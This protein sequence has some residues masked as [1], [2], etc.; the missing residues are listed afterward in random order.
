MK[1]DNNLTVESRLIIRFESSERT[2]IPCDL[3][4]RAPVITLSITEIFP[5]FHPRVLQQIGITEFDTISR[6][7]EAPVGDQLS[8][9]ETKR[10]LLEN[11]YRYP[12]S[13]ISTR[14]DLLESL[15]RIHY[16]KILIP[17]TLVQHCIQQYKSVS[18]DRSLPEALFRPGFFLSYIQDAWVSFLEALN[19]NEIP[20]IP[21]DHPSLRAYIDTF[22][23]E[24]ILVPAEI[25]AHG[26]LPAWTRCGILID[27][28]RD[29]KHHLQ[30]L[31]ERIRNN[32]PQPEW[33]YEEWLH[34][35]WIWAEL[36]YLAGKIPVQ[37]MAGL[38]EE[39]ESSQ[40]VI[41]EQF[42]NWLVANFSLIQSLSYL[43]RPI[44]VHQIP[45][46]IQ[47]KKPEKTALIVF[48]GLALDQWLIIREKLRPF[49]KAEE[50]NVFAWV[51]TLTSI[52]RRAIFSGKPPFSLQDSLQD[53]DSEV[54]YWE[55]LWSEYGFRKNEIGYL[56]G[57]SLKKEDDILAIQQLADKKILGIVVNT[58]DDYIKNSDDARHSLNNRIEE[59]LDLG[60]VQRLMSALIDAGYDIFITSDHGN[61]NCTG[62]GLLSDG[63][64][65]DEKSLRVRIYQNKHLTDI[66]KTKAPDSVHWPE[67]NTG[68]CYSV[69]L[70]RG[71]SAFYNKGESCI[72]HGGISLEEV[73]VPFIHITEGT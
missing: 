53:Y 35:S 33:T 58:I 47:T 22:F 43:P 63:S 40:N 14:T 56:K 36:R 61:I 38:Q 46:Y 27:P 12:V 10:F 64:I 59:W 8:E 23:L 62:S 7:V 54:R 9:S 42:E 1:W 19:N 32:L 68:F 73:I 57:L 72:S 67:E 48:D 5:S 65:S 31:L 4:E 17:E 16:R 70:S 11:V 55:A 45:H 66:G 71:T 21:F 49:L 3:K 52:S 39:L 13:Q 28:V 26:N 60:Y 24:G 41:E 51:P 20:D 18:D 29:N 37:S 30:N 44:L 34:F 69:L 2:K 6:T 50:G 15:F 25:S